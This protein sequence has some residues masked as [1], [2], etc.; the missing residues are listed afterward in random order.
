MIRGP[1]IVNITEE[2]LLD[3]FGK[4]APVKDIRL[5]RHKQTG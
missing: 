2:E 5:V 1:S 3:V 4:I